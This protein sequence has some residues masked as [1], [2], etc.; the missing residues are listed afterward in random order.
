MQAERN[1]VVIG[2][3]QIFRKIFENQG[4]KC[5]WNSVFLF[6]TV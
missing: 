6:Y 4:D 2:F 3:R 5:S 1:H